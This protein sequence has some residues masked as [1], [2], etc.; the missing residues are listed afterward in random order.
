MDRLDTALLTPAEVALR[1]GVSRSWLYHAAK[2]GRIPCVRLG[3]DDGPVRF[4]EAELAVWLSR[5]RRGRSPGGRTLEAKTGA[6]K[7]RSGPTAPR[8]VAQ[9]DV[10]PA[11]QLSWSL[12]DRTTPRASR[13]R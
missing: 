10:A 5:A 1:L 8:R 4:L 3:G 13:R 9:K 11:E 2:E 7:E 6:S 12:A